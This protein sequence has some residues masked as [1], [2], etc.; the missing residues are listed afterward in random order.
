MR[1]RLSLDMLIRVLR[2]PGLW[3]VAGLLVLITAFHHAQWLDYPPF[4]TRLA[5]YL[6]VERHAFERIL[7]LA[8]IVWAGFLF[9]RWGA[10]LA[11]L[12]ALAFMLPRAIFVSLYPR[13][14]LFEIGAVFLV[15]NAVSLTSEALRRERQ[16][17]M[18]LAALNRVS[19]VVSQSLELSQVLE[20]SIDSVIEVMK[21]DAALVFLLDKAL[22][23]LALNAYRGIATETARAITDIE[24]GE[25]FNGRVAQTGKPLWVE[26]TSRDPG[27]TRLAVSLENIRSQLIVPLQSNGAVVGTLCVAMRSTRRFCQHEVE[28]LVAIG[29]QIGVAVEKAR[30]YQQTR[31][32]TRQLQ[33]S[34]AKYRGLFENAYDAIWLHDMQ[35]NIIAANISF[36]ALTGYNL[37]ELSSIKAVDLITHGCV[38]AV[39]EKEDVLRS[40]GLVGCLSEVTLVMKDGSQALVQLSTTPVFSAG[41]RVAIQHIARDVTME[42]RMQENLRF[43]LQEV[44]RAQEEERKRIA[45]ELHDDTVQALV[46]LSRQLEDLTSRCCGLAEEERALLESLRQH[47]NNTMEGVRRL[48]QDLRPPILDHLGLLPTLEWLASDIATR[49]GIRV[50]VKMCGEAR[51]LAAEVELTLFRIVQEALQ[52]VWRHSEATSA[53]MA[54]ESGQN[55]IHIAVRDNGKGFDVPSSARDLVKAGKLG[56]A[57][58]EERARLVGGTLSV[59]SEPGKGTVVTVVVPA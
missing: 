29:N 2:T 30:L 20:S 50:E 35:G 18:H 40:D 54:V 32:V 49:S 22:G 25:G 51:R 47:T 58:M 3:L 23:K 19:Q 24:L 43:H 55:E 59:Q 7:Y 21:V 9:G 38:D 10:V 39:R 5:D 44:T 42:R 6:G 14:A 26:D 17:R 48:S 53:E 57:G 46:V 34:E 28:V 52:N 1:G 36:V 11:S 27:L 13:D 31:D 45:R 33:T 41:E 16:R 12:A 56:L 15:G 37:D 8:P 4:L